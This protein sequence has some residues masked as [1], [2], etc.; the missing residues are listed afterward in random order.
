MKTCVESALIKN[1]FVTNS[2]IPSPADR[3]RRSRARMGAALT[4]SRGT[5]YQRKQAAIRTEI[6]RRL[7]DLTRWGFSKTAAAKIL[8]VSY[9]SIRRWKKNGVVPTTSKCGRKSKAEKFKISQEMLRRIE[10][11][12]LAGMG[13]EAAWR[14]VCSDWQCDRELAAFVKSAKTLPPSFLGLTRLNRQKA[15]IV[16]AQHLGRAVAIIE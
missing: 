16:Q 6:L 1:T 9:S 12:Q 8:G 7:E 13:N 3:H 2:G 5:R 4:F 15:A 11:L 10:V 14:K